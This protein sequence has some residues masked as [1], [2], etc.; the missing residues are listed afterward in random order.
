MHMLYDSMG[1]ER[2]VD[3]LRSKMAE[4]SVGG[5]ELQKKRDNGEICLTSPLQEDQNYRCASKV[6]FL[7]A[8][9]RLEREPEVHL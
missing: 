4:K 8:S 2:D 9:N 7:L 5:D 1:F 6:Y 3:H